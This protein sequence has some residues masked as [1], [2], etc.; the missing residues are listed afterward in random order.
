MTSP[1]MEKVAADFAGPFPLGTEEGRAAY[2]GFAAILTPDPE[3]RWEAAE[4][5]GIG[6]PASEWQ[7]WDGVGP[8]R[9]VLY[10][11]G[12]G[13]VI[14]SPPTWRKFAARLSRQAGVRLLNFDYRMAPE[15]P[16]PAAVDDT[17]AAYRWLLENGWSADR[18]AL[19]GDSAGGGLGIAAMTVLRD[20]G[21][22]LPACHMALCPWVDLTH[23]AASID[24]PG[25]EDPN[26]ELRALAEA[27]ADKY[28][29]GESPEHPLASPLFCQL[30]GLPPVQVEV[31]GRDGIRDDALRIAAALAAAGVEVGSS[32]TEGA[33][34][35]YHMFAPDTPEAREGTARLADFLQS[36]LATPTPTAP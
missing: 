33:I 31:S 15:H 24:D 12:G 14:G 23:G 9:V 4:V 5:G 16:F 19:G 2:D 18:I 25:V 28:L 30:A 21:D 32:D 29:C 34:H 10:L 17:V 7:W 20:A 26:P 8:E 11:H 36:Q 13:Y 6:G 35:G 1:E 22:P 3:A 27:M